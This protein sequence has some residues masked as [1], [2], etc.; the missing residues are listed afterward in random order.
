[1]IEDLDLS[2]EQKEQLLELLK[3]QDNRIKYNHIKT[4]FQD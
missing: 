2:R 3:E 1:M 4:F